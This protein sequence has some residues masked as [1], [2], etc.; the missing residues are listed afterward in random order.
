M[1][2]FGNGQAG[3]QQQHGSDTDPKLMHGTLL[4]RVGREA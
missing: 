4:L 1:G 2:R 3:A